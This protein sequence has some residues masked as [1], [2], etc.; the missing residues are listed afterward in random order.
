MQEQ[1]T[2]TKSYLSVPERFAQLYNVAF[3][4]GEPIINP[5]KLQNLDST[6]SAVLKNSSFEYHRDIIKKYEDDTLLIICGIENQDSVHYAMPLRH[7]LYDAL[8]YHSQWQNLKRQHRNSKD[9]HSAEF[10]SG[11]SASDLFTPVITLCIYWGSD[12]WNGPK[13]L[14]EMLDIPPVLEHYKDK[15]IG[16]YPLNLLEIRAISNLEQYQGELKALFGFLKY[17]NSKQELQTFIAKNSSL[18][19]NIDEETAQAISIL[20]NV[21]NL[22]QYITTHNENSKGGLNMC[23]AIDDMIMEGHT[24]GKAEGL[25]L[26]INALIEDNLED[27]KPKDT[28]LKKLQKRFHLTAEK[29]EE[30]FSQY[31]SN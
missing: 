14:H 9:L 8:Q 5:Q 1:N 25:L 4:Q 11:L 18:F 31:S 10:L 19:R 28:I 12:P 21:K 27:G 20:G 7:M 6:E 3:F 22:D 16:N 23:K 24:E 2:I 29:A 15:L 17:Q 13:N 26:G 30:Y